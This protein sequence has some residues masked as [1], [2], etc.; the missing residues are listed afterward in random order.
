[1]NRYF[2]KLTNRLTQLDDD[3]ET[4]DGFEIAQ[5]MGIALLGLV[6]TA[7]FATALEAVGVDVISGIRTQ[8]GL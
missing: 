2:I 1:M 7:G 8:L 6:V 3:V 4:E 5:A